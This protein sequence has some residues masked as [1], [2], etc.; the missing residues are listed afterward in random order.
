M[1]FKI[2]QAEVKK[3]QNNILLGLLLTVVL[4]I[5]VF[6]G[7]ESIKDKYND[8]LIASFI[9][10][11]LFANIINGIRHFRWKYIIKKHQIEVLDDQVV[12]LEGDVRTVLQKSQINKAHIK[13]RQE[14]VT[15][16]IV[17]L[18]NGNK[19]RLEGYEEMEALAKGL[20]DRLK[21]EQVVG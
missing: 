1:I 17:Q 9:L 6:M 21:P 20:T 14:K 16:I 15:R 4:A 3:R 12:F 10:F 8:F 19:I 18:V 2:G 5:I 11:F 7:D 13:R